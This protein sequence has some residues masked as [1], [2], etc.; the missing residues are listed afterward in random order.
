M[1][2]DFL[3]LFGQRMLNVVCKQSRSSK[4]N[5]GNCKNVKTRF[6]KIDSCYCR[7]WT[8]Q[9]HF[10]L[11]VAL[12]WQKCTKHKTLNKNNFL[13]KNLHWQPKTYCK[14]RKLYQNVRNLL[15]KSCNASSAQGHCTHC[16]LC[17]SSECAIAPFSRLY[18]QYLPSKPLCGGQSFHLLPSL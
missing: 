18:T 11:A 9:S 12:I 10:I 15:Q 4:N 13:K 6:C 1:A 17:L 8:Y 2:L 7:P 16:T 5:Y 14:Y 3:G